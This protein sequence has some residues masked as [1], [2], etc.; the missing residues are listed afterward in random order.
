MNKSTNQSNSFNLSDITSY[1]AGVIQSQAHRKLKKQV[2]NFLKPH[3]I[4]MME[5]FALGL[6]KDSQDKGMRL[7]ELAGQLQTTLPYTTNLINGLMHKG[8]LTRTTDK[9][10]SRAKF[11]RLVPGVEETCNTIERNLREKMRQL[12]YADITP[13]E[14]SIYIKV[15]FTIASHDE[16]G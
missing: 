8:Y 10:D 11:L 12:I 5:W 6:I 13:N 14:L 7:T 1:Q 2:T 4:T 3:G 9:N 15:L 16:K